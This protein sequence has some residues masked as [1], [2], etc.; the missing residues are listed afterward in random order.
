MSDP[1]G[2]EGAFGAEVCHAELRA[3][4]RSDERPCSVG[5]AQDLDRS[6]LL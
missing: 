2:P 1:A 6:G 5:R 3:G 4:G